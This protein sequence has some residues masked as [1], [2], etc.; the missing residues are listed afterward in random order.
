MLRSPFLSLLSAVLLVAFLAACSAPSDA[1][2]L[3][4]VDEPAP[5]LAGPLV[6]GG[7]LEAKDLQG[8]PLVINFWASWCGPCRREQPMLQRA[9]E[10]LEGGDV[11]FIGVNS[12]EGQEATAV[13][14]LK[15]FGVT[16][17]S[18]Q[19]PLGEIAAAYGIDAGLPATVVVDASGRIRYRRLGEVT[20]AQLDEML[21]AVATGS[22]ATSSPSPSSVA[23][24]SS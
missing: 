24:P 19:D 14:H 13:Q 9:W 10:E 21:A 6:G 20:K 15:E 17:P 11:R 5:T 3:T 23:T 22:S 1:F 16:Y 18:V 8:Q 12:R 2:A 7:Q 4:P